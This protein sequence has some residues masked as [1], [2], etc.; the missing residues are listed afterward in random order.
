MKRC[1]FVAMLLAA[2]LFGC[3][4]VTDYM[5]GVH[6]PIAREVG[7]AG[8]AA[9]AGS[10]EHARAELDHA[11]QSWDDVRKTTAAFADHGPMEEIDALFAQLEVAAQWE[12]ALGFSTLCAYLSQSLEAMGEAHGLTWWNLL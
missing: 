4:Y 5:A 8:E 3:L 11:R 1:W 6:T 7:K 10:W 2:L 9:M 12:D